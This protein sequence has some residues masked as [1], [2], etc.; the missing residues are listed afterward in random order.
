[1]GCTGGVTEVVVGGMIGRDE[2][3]EIDCI[4]ALFG[5]QKSSVGVPRCDIGGLVSSQEKCDILLAAAGHPLCIG[6]KLGTKFSVVFK[7]TC[8]SKSAQLSI[9]TRNS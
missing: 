9:K 7:R 3:H 4:K 5:G 6:D 2:Q 1:M 8:S